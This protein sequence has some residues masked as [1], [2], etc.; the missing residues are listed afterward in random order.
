MVVEQPNILGN[1][2]LVAK[3]VPLKLTSSHLKMDGWKTIVS[4]WDSTHFQGCY[5]SFREGSKLGY[6]PRVLINQ[7]AGVNC[8]YNPTYNLPTIRIQTV[9]W[10]KSP[11]RQCFGRT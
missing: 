4:F 3:M 9:F 6:D 1:P 11:P 2:H 8:S 7:L 5:V 10:Q